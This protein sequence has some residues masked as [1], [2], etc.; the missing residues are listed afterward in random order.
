[1]KVWNNIYIVLT[2]NLTFDKI[3]RGRF[4]YKDEVGKIYFSDNSETKGGGYID[5]YTSTCYYRKSQNDQYTITNFK[6]NYKIPQFDKP[7]YITTYT[8]VD[9]ISDYDFWSDDT[10]N[11][12]NSGITDNL[13]VTIERTELRMREKEQ[14][15]P[16][17]GSQDWIDTGKVRDDPDFEIQ[18]DTCD[19]GIQYR[20]VEFGEICDGVN[21]SKTYKLQRK[22][23]CDSNWVDYSPQIE[24]IGEV[25]EYD[26]TECGTH[27]YKEE[28]STES[29]CG[30]YLNE[31]YNANLT[32]TS[33][34]FIKYGYIKR[35]D[36]QEWDIIDCGTLLDY[37]LDYANSFECGWSTT[38]IENSRDEGLCGDEAMEKYPLITN[39][40]S[41]SKY[42]VVTKTTYKT[43]SY[44]TN[45]DDMT[46]DEW[47]WEVIDIEYL[48]YLNESNSCDC[49]YYYLQWD[50][51]DEYSCG[52]ALG[53]GY[54][55][56]TQYQKYIEN[57][58]CNGNLLE[59]SGNIEWREYDN[60]SCE[61]G[62]R[63][64]GYSID[65]SVGYE[66]ICGNGIEGLEENFIYYQEYYYTECVDGSNR[67]YDKE[68]IKYIKADHFSEDDYTCEFDENLNAN[69]T[70]VVTTYRTY[71]DMND[72]TR[73]FVDCNG[74]VVENVR[75]YEKSSD[76]GYIEEWAVSGTAC[77]GNIENGGQCI[78]YSKYEAEYFR[79]SVDGGENW[80]TPEP[81]QY[82]Y[83][84]LIEAQSEE[85]GYVPVL[86]QWVLICPNLTY[87]N[88]YSGD[89]C[90]ICETYNG[91]PTMFA[92]EKKQISYDGGKTWED[93]VPLETRT[94]KILKWKADKCGYT[95]D[96]FET[97][98]TD[99]YCDGK[100]LYGTKTIWVS[101]DNGESWREV[102]GSSRIEIKE[103]NSPQCQG[104]EGGA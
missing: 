91:A 31:N 85:C 86:E 2:Y 77:C 20:W 5:L 44:P 100:D 75:K 15:R 66:Y 62:Y 48:P 11:I 36:E 33:K 6:E 67:V 42:D 94:E 83:G 52:S 71:Y 24:K 47:V 92:I 45:T 40:S 98:W 99:E 30:S 3:K 70:K 103:A 1:M 78:K 17:D 34:Y 27:E 19:C 63:I 25:I 16:T 9:V 61:C 84:D 60:Q 13:I 54:T 21:K 46:E 73:K 28:W 56:T 22:N 82:R 89:G 76:C 43:A 74:R 39:L 57:K 49:G 41:T 104:E 102:E 80:V 72:S 14:T 35:I 64:S 51:V 37:K 7:M 93:I 10:T 69:T 26:S 95:G 23:D 50:A 88:A 97:R 87:E 68:K 90:T 18:Y 59:P 101:S 65:E 8:N 29:F 38:K 32:P 55:E 4:H 53:S 79:Y 96:I 81:I 12:D 58:Y